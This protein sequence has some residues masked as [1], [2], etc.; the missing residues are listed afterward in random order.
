MKKSSNRKVFFA[1]T[2]IMVIALMMSLSG[3]TLLSAK[4]NYI[5]VE[6]AISKETV[7]IRF[8]NVPVKEV[9]NEI[10]DQTGIGFALSSE[11]S[12]A[13]G[14]V[15]IDVKD[16]TVTK[17]LDAILNNTGFEYQVVNN[18]IVITKRAPQKGKIK[19]SG[20]VMDNLRDPVIGALI[21]MKGTDKAVESDLDGNFSLVLDK[22]GEV[23]VSY[24]GYKPFTLTVTHDLIGIVVKLE[25]DNV[26]EDVVVTGIFNKSRETFTGSVTS[27]SEKELVNFKGQNLIATLKNI[28]PVLNV[29]TN[30][31][32][33]SDPNVLPDLSI[34]GN[35]SLGQS[36][37]ELEIGVQAALNTPLII[38][39]GFEISLEKL[40]DYNDEDIASMNIL[41]DASATAIYGSRGANGVIVITT[42][43]PE[44]GQ[45]KVYFKAGINLEMPDLTSYNLMNAREKLQLEYENG[46]YDYPYD[47]DI[48]VAF[49]QLYHENL[50]KVNEGVDTY[51]IGQPI[52]VGVGQRYN[53]NL[54]GGNNTFRWRTSLGYNDV[55]GA[56][57][58]SDRKNFNGSIDLQYT[59]KR[60]IFSNQ[61][62]ITYN[63]AENSKYGEFSDYALMNPYWPIY[64]KNGDLIKSYTRP[65]SNTTNTVG[66]PLYNS[67]LNTYNRSNYTQLVNNFSIEWTIVDELRLRGQFGISKRFDKSDIF[68]PAEHTKFETYAVS[69]A[70]KKGSYTYGTGESFSMNGNL[71]LSWSKTFAKKHNIYLG[72]DFYVS[73]NNSYH[74][75]FSAIGFPNANL[76][77]MGSSL[78]YSDGARPSSGESKS[79]AVGFTANVNYSYDNRYFV[80]GSFRSDGSSLFGG[81]NRFAPFW[82]VGLGWNIHHEK[83]L[84]NQ[85]FISNMKLR[86][87]V[88]ESGSQNFSSYQALSTYS[89]YTDK[90]YGV[91]NGAY[92]MGHGNPNLR[93]QKVYQ[94]N[95]GLDISILD[96]RIS[97]AVDVYSKDTKDLLSRRDL[98]ASTGFTSYTENIGEIS[99][100]GIEGMLS[101]N[102]IR[103]LQKEI[104]WSL[105]GRIAYNKNTIVKLSDALK[106][107]TEAALKENIEIN[108]LLFEGDPTNAIY[109]VRS[110]GID[111]STG[112]ELYLDKN[113]NITDTWKAS[114]KVFLGTYDP[115][116]R[117]N[118]SSFFQWKGL[119]VNL[120]FGYH[121]GGYQYNTT[122]LNKVEIHKSMI[123]AGNVDKRVYSDRWQQPGDVKF[124]KKIDEKST[125]A[126][127]RFVMKDN[128][129]ELQN[130]AVQ[131]TFDGPMLKKKAKIQSI[132]VGMNMSDIFYLSTIKR[133]RGTSYPFAR[134]A[135]LSLSL[136]F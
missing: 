65:S 124:F 24:L 69:D 77:F 117:G 130:I 6:Q 125:K 76:D 135:S 30:N 71:T 27:I 108:S 28:D 20:T 44:V 106:K 39:D 31:Y 16:A 41:K 89:Y 73:D 53:V 47:M 12:K 126:T 111:P 83:F 43:A 5:H 129:L 59:H 10:K 100:K 21:Y 14:N 104:I 2:S 37:E 119:S 127:S 131:Y 121:F 36:L 120:A 40:M 58:G 94:W 115:K 18:Q 80:D 51:W 64:D 123:A 122:L 81:N 3:N 72:G 60:L 19:I 128:V 75:S 42:K 15:S 79:R 56:M 70:M 105:T 32:I 99:N 87:S 26:L 98:Q 54:T 49:K 13:I 8:R 90:K 78:G 9:L 33:G 46:V 133:E 1:K 68:Y 52:R 103:N 93:W 25:P 134:H 101:V 74:Y 136:T 57:K 86:G 107:D 17:A 29:A 92:I 62:S 102:L 85:S 118:I 84:K 95:V 67:T 45:I 112:N 48:D 114:D 97:A 66:N 63:K 96:G 38:M 88:G 22:S 113:G 132:M 61:T 11:V 50:K 34:R 7:T 55:A 109:A 116:F 35:S 82:S 91:W 4:E 110:L 23:E